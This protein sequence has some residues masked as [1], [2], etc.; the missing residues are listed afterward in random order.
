MQWREALC[1]QLAVLLRAASGANS[2][3]FLFCA[4]CF[5]HYVLCDMFCV[6]YVYNLQCALERSLMMQLVG[7]SASCTLT[8]PQSGEKYSQEDD[9][10]RCYKSKLIEQWLRLIEL[11][12]RIRALL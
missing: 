12:E 1:N 11:K 6:Q 4:E 8:R 2:V 10:R 3:A 7:S 5:A 9:V